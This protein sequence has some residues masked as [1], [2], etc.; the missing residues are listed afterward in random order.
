MRLLD[1][2][3]LRNVGAVIVVLVGFFRDAESLARQAGQ[4]ERCSEPTMRRKPFLASPKST[5]KAIPFD[6][7]RKG[8]ILT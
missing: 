4:K 1:T 8:L 7:V 2:M 5:P 3:A 6:K